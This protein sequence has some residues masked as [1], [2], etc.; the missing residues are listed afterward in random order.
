MEI[1]RN[2]YLQE[3][4]DRRENG[5]IKVIT[6][7]RRAGK[8]YLLF[9][10]FYQYL[11]SEGIPED[12]ILRIPLDDDDYEELRERHVLSAF[13]KSKITDG[14]MYYLLL[15]EVQFCENFESV[16]NGLSRKE[17][18][19]IYVTGSNSRMLSSDI[20]TQFRDR[21]DEIHM[22]PLTFAEFYAATPDKIHALRDYSIFG[23]MPY[24]LELTESEEKINYLKTLFTETYLRDIIERNHLKNSSEILEIL[25]D[26]ISSAIGSLTNTSKL[27][28]RFQS[29]KHI[30]IS[31]STIAQYLAW[32]EEAY[33]ISG[34][35]RYDVKGSRYFSTPMKY[36]FTDIGLRNARLNFRQ[37][38]QTHTM[39]N[40]I[41]NDLIS[42]G[43]SVDV[44]VVPVRRKEGERRVSS[45][46][47][48]DFIVN[49][50]TGRCYIQSALRIDSKE[51]QSQE[52]ASLREVKD[53]F[54]KIVVLGD[55][56]IPW[57]D[58]NGIYY[59]GIQ[60]FLLKGLEKI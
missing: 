41:Y 29:E 16:L 60:D 7:L 59:V 45:Q 4:L 51:K 46:L 42:R 26:F 15:D 14:N 49:R 38:E 2:H 39:E 21:G 30:S 1:A 56:I 25:L 35:K 5:S 34:A 50:G 55:D 27:E 20:L 36:Y 58:E 32:F 28:S 22:N 9:H 19:D 17:N 3:L 6:G 40:M 8:S 52:T 31:H 44:G 11:L 43:Y 47:E 12:H 37:V 13:I 53:S 54:R 10:I 24:L 48:I 18:L 57:H 33:L 23:G